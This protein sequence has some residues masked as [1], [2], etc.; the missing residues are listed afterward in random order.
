MIP[1]LISCSAVV[2][3]V[4]LPASPLLPLLL[5]VAQAIQNVYGVM[6]A[7]LL[8]GKSVLANSKEQFNLHLSDASS[9]CQCLFLHS[10]QIK[11][12]ALDQLV[13]SASTAPS[14]YIPN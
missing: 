2:L 1:L 4:C 8:C 5:Q 3:V 7:C 13:L 6:H 9:I 10:A 14:L 12:R 11:L